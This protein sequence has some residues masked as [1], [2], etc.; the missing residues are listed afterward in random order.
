MIL[1]VFET[2]RSLVLTGPAAD[3][4]R[5]GSRSRPLRV[6]LVGSRVLQVKQILLGALTQHGNI[7][8]INRKPCTIVA[9]PQIW[10]ETPN[11]LEQE[12]KQTNKQDMTFQLRITHSGLKSPRANSC[13]STE[14]HVVEQLQWYARH[15]EGP[16]SSTSTIHLSG[17]PVQGRHVLFGFT[18]TTIVACCM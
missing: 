10:G 4:S 1:Q 3:V 18:R 15:V 9:V 17:W 11:P 8:P 13:R 2:A 5:N 14:L 6:G 12:K 7:L 16:A